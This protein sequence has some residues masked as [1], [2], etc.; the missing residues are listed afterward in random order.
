M[1]ALFCFVLLV[2]A[3]WFILLIFKEE[4]MY[5]IKEFSLKLKMRKLQKHITHNEY[6]KVARMYLYSGDYIQFKILHEVMCINCDAQPYVNAI[7]NKMPSYE[8]RHEDRNH[9]EIFHEYIENKKHRANMSFCEFYW[10]RYCTY[11]CAFKYSYLDN[12]KEAARVKPE[13]KDVLRPHLLNLLNTMTLEERTECFCNSYRAALVNE[14]MSMYEI[15]GSVEKFTQGQDD[16]KPILHLTDDE[17]REVTS[18]RKIHG[19]AEDM[20]NILNNVEKTEECDGETCSDRE[21]KD[22]LNYFIKRYNEGIAVKKEGT[23]ESDDILCPICGYSVARNDDYDD[24][25][26]NHCPE[27]GTKLVY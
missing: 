16:F 17:F 11:E 4:V 1:K 21:T 14:I 5:A 22:A 9:H 7:I 20:K 24:M 27:C 15:I 2:E 19:C 12:F 10:T 25:R 13:L 23:D 6:L 18:M 3:I 8:K 26:P